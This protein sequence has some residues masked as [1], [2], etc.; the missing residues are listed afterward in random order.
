MFEFFRSKDKAARY[1]LTAILLLVAVSMLLYLVPGGLGDPSASAANDTVA[2]IGDER[3]TVRDV[4]LQIR[5]AMQGRNFPPEMLK[6]FVPEIVNQ[7]VS[8]R[9]IAYQAQRMGFAISDQELAN[10]LR[11]M[12]AQLFQGGF[13]PEIYTAWCQQQGYASCTEFEGNMKKQMLLNRLQT[14]V[15]EGI[16]VTPA[17]VEEEYRRRTEK[18]KLDYI[19]FNADQLRGQVQVSP[20]ELQ[21]YFNANRPSYMMPE[22]RSFEVLVASE[23]KI[24]AGITVPEADLRKAY[25][26]NLDRYRTGERVKV[27]HILVKT[28]G[29]PADGVTKA[30]AKANDLLKQV[31]GGADFAE[32]AKKNSD[33]PGSASRGGDLD[34]VQRGQMVKNFEE[35]AFNTKKGETSN[36][37]R[38]EYGFHIVQ[39]L[40]REDAR[41]KPFEEVKAELE[42]EVKRKTVFDRLQSAVDQAQSALVKNPSNGAQIAQQFGLSHY[43]VNNASKGDPI[44]EIGIVAQFEE[45]LYGLQKNGVT[46]VIPAPGN[47][48]A[49]GVVTNITPARQA[50]LAEVTEQV[51]SAL[52]STKARALLQAKQAEAA[53][54]VAELGDLAKVAA[55]MGATVRTTAEFSRDGAAEGLGSASYF[56]EAFTKPVGTTLA[57]VAV[58]DQVVVAKVSAKIEADLSKLAGEREG[59]ITGIKQR[60]F[61][62]RR[63]LFQDGLVAQLV[64]QGKVKINE[65]AIKRLQNSYG[66]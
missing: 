49:V 62:E 27:R 36:V 61:T 9:A 59:I 41:V 65:E 24:G 15:G 53:K 6:N 64:K 60:K 48:L 19:A 34:W 21:S 3:L 37:V 5:G 58:M 25:S 46:P 38:T 32:L 22:K 33:D 14:M 2:E 11:G 26:A 4:A 43:V 29:L 56:S 1:M 42:T 55:A 23:E 54:K 17:E 50:E 16:V 57:P 18:V 52:T 40:D 20:E 8:E 7:M 30:E 45:S 47:K 44:Q 12:L 39:V 13:K 31:K 10:S 63:D 51:R 28:E 35:T 66:S